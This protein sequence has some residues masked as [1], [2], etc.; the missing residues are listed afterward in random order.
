MNAAALFTSDLIAADTS[1]DVME[2]SAGA[3]LGLLKLHRATGDRETY[4]T[5]LRSAATIFSANADLKPKGGR[6]PR[7]GRWKAAER[8]VPWS[9]RLRLRTHIIGCRDR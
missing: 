6:V 3:I 2:G 4:S 8:H 5:A 9:G 1:F 7:M